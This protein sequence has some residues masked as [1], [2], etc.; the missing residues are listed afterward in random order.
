MCKWTSRS[1][2]PQLAECTLSFIY[3]AVEKYELVE[4]VIWR[5]ILCTH[6][7]PISSL[8]ED[9]PRK[10]HPNQTKKSPLC[11]MVTVKLWFNFQNANSRIALFPPTKFE[12]NSQL[13]SFWQ[14]AKVVASRWS[15][16]EIEVLNQSRPRNEFL[17]I[18]SD[19]SSSH[20]WAPK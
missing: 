15:I 4:M 16:G 6:K 10:L 14:S 18:S 20:Y 12:E 7:T 3:I 17:V 2:L 5:C 9:L 11:V 8:R 19:K 13:P 1:N